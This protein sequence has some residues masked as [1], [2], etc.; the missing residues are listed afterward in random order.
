MPRKELVVQPILNYHLFQRRE[1]TSWRPWGGFHNQADIEQEKK[2]IQSE[3]A[4]ITKQSDF[5]IKMLPLEEV[6]SVEQAEALAKK[7][8]DVRLIYAATGDLSE[9]EKLI[10]TDNNTILF[11]RHKSGPVYLWYE[12][13]HPRLLRKTVDVYG[14]PGLDTDDAVVDKLEDVVWRLR[15]F[16]A[17]KN[18]LGSKIVAVG[19]ASGW[20][21]GGQ[22]APRI[23]V[24]KWKLDIQAVSYDDL[25][26]RLGAAKKD[27]NRI[28][29]A[30]AR[31]DDYLKTSGTELQTDRGFVERSFLLTDVFED[32]M[33]EVGAPAITVNHCMGTIMPICET[34]ACLTL[35]VI[36]DSGEMAF[37]ESDFV[38]IPSGL[39]LHH[40][41]GLPVFLQD[42][43]YPHHGTVTVAHCTAPRK[44]DGE[45][46]EPTLIQTH[47]ESD[48]GAAPKVEMK[49]GQYVT[50]IDPDFED[51]KWLGFG[52]TIVDNPNMDIC[53]AQID[54]DIDGDWE[55]LVAEMRGFHWMLCYGD[56]RQ[57]TG[58]ALK[59]LGIDWV[60][61][62]KGTEGARTV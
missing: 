36:N 8:A 11:I 31:A 57:E 27:N 50:V 29:K 38:V 24:D 30:M 23:A 39:L 20:G 21:A 19:N 61:V 28:K 26:Q 54:I 60:D 13:A 17:L 62:S 10:S 25:A 2:R 7:P 58:Y 37:C 49:L 44:M 48:Y 40:I 34:T 9:I 18:T 59:K 43:T 47:F 55:R 15:S 53:R 33:L 51:E 35:S 1:Q 52:G 45:H 46:P 3:L 14:Q 4:E 56:F 16:Y 5:S 22:A 42:P 6:S 32:L 12:I 41:S